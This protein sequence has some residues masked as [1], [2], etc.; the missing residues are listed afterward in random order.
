MKLRAIILKLLLISK[1]LIFSLGVHAYPQEAIQINTN[2]FNRYVPSQFKSIQ[3]DFFNMLEMLSLQKLPSGLTSEIIKLTKVLASFK[4]QCY[5]DNKNC[6]EIAAQAK[7]HLTAILKLDSPK[8]QTYQ[9]HELRFH[10]EFETFKTLNL[11]LYFH[12]VKFNDQYLA[13]SSANLIKEAVQINKQ[14]QIWQF[15]VKQFLTSNILKP[16][17]K[18]MREFWIHFIDPIDFYFFTTSNQIDF[19][20]KRVT[21]LNFAINE[22][23]FLVTKKNKISDTSILNLAITLHRRWNSILKII[24]KP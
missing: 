10:E 15:Q 22:F 19:L 16:Y 7:K 21:D 14:I 6:I 9:I 8:L 12:F 1:L 2:E 13:N 3:L 24:L 4:A 11:S 20:T 23:S 5:Q 18:F 17:D